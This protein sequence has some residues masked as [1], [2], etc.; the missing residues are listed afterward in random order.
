MDIIN[1]FSRAFDIIPAWLLPLFLTLLSVFSLA[2]IIEKLRLL[3]NLKIPPDE[4]IESIFSFSEAEPG[5]PATNSDMQPPFIRG[6]F[7]IHR[8]VRAGQPIH[9]AIEN[10]VFRQSRRFRAGLP[11]LNTIA[12]IAPLLGLLGTVTGIMKSFGGFAAGHSLAGTGARVIMGGLEEALATTALG[13]IVAI[14]SLVVYNYL[15]RRLNEYGETLEIA[16]RETL[17]EVSADRKEVS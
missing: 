7:I 15:A 14:P 3:K 11:A 12:S 2:I 4:S 10:E 1:N 5:D 13:L 9:E 17:R 16:A 8:K 6:L